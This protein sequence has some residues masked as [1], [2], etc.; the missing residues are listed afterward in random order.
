MNVAFDWKGEYRQRRSA[1]RQALLARRQK[2]LTE[3]PPL[4]AWQESYGEALREIG[5]EAVQGNGGEAKALRDRVTAL[6]EEKAVLL[7]AAGYPANALD[8]QYQ[9]EKCRD[10]GYVDGVECQ[11]VA[12][13]RLE[14]EA[15]HWGEELLRQQ[16][17][18]CYDANVFPEENGQ[19]GRMERLRELGEDY[20]ER[21]PE[22]DPPGLFLTGGAG[23]GKSF[24]LHCVA[25][26]VMERGYRVRKI[27]GYQFHQLL[28]EKVFNG[29]NAIYRE[30]L[31]ADLLLFDDLG[32][33]PKTRNSITESH[34]FA[35]LDART[36]NGRQPMLVATNYAL[37][38]IDRLYGERC[39]SRLM[40]KRS[41][42]ALA[43]KG[44]DVRLRLA[45]D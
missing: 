12:A 21:F 9:C 42:R 5:L 7:A 31:G 17:F 11:C 44:E 43:L 28:M 3:S 24:F 16:C 41:F 4:A 6:E 33:E 22:N 34:F 23:L 25:G 13:L 27:T 8:L 19:R 36:A 15:R 10:Y 26:R 29:D 40:D 35:L 38:E 2:I 30:L 37:D 32:S 45:R 39:S 18:A 14:Y 1:A 20:A